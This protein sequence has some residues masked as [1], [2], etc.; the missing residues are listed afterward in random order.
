MLFTIVAFIS[1]SLFAFLFQLLTTGQF[2]SFKELIR[3]HV[4]SCFPLFSVECLLTCFVLFV[5]YA[6]T[7]FFFELLPYIRKLREYFPIIRRSVAITTILITFSYIT[8][9]TYHVIAIIFSQ[10]HALFTRHFEPLEIAVNAWFS[11]L[12]GGSTSPTT[13]SSFSTTNSSFSPWIVLGLTSLIAILFFSYF[14][15]RQLALNQPICPRRELHGFAHAASLRFSCTMRSQAQLLSF[16]VFFRN[17]AAEPIN[18]SRSCLAEIHRC[19][20]CTSQRPGSY[21]LLRK[22]YGLKLKATLHRLQLSILFLCCM[23]VIC[24]FFF[25]PSCCVRGLTALT[26]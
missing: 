22:I 26:D 20:W 5:L 13:H 18:Y 14:L 25:L 11:P 9:P 19:C 7:T 12:L 6:L 8:V 24:L 15:H 21:Y 17:P 16:T 4:T 2:A 3:L 10:S 23:L 1:S